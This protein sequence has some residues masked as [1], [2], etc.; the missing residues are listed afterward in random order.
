MEGSGHDLF[1]G[2]VVVFACRNG[3][4]QWKP[5]LKWS[6]CLPKFETDTFQMEARSLAATPTHTHERAPGVRNVNTS[7][8]KE[9]NVDAVRY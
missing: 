1:Q 9:S 3:R 8:L 4:Q 6:V 2:K 7:S 5:K